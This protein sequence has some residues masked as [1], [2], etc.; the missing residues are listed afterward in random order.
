MINLICVQKEV[1]LIVILNHLTMETIVLNSKATV[2]NSFLAEIRD[3]QIQTDPMRFRQNLIRLGEIFAYEISRRL[4]YAEKSILTPLG[5]AIE[6]LPQ[7]QLVLA[8]VLRAGLPF[9]E[10]FLSIFDR[11]EN[12]FISAY[13][14]Y[15]AGGDFDIHIEYVSSPEIDGKTVILCDPMLASGNS[16]VLSYQALLKI[17]TPKHVHIASIIAS[18]DGVDYIE[19]NI[20]STHVTLWCGAVDEELNAK[21]YIVPGL[22]DVGDLAYGKKRE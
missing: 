10:G 22:G 4:H 18:Q 11:A 16:M 17:G 19:K 5:V 3:K 20:H 8:A 2:L 7:D 12:C 1:N 15:S 13:R 9:H 14:K 6:K 21:S